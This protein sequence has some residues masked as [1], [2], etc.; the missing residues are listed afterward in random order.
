MAIQ[1]KTDPESGKKYYNV[2]ISIRSKLVPT[3]RVQKRKTKIETLNKARI[4]EKELYDKCY[5]ELYEKENRGCT[6]GAVVE[7]WNNY[8]KTD[9]FD[10]IAPHTLHDYTQSMRKWTQSIWDKPAKEVSRSD[11]KKV[12]SYMDEDG[13]SKNFQSKTKGV[14]NRIFTWG[15]EEE[16]ITGVLQSP[17]IGLKVSRRKERV[18]TILNKNEISILLKSAKEE[19]SPW[20]PIWFTAIHTGC[21][22]GELFALSWEDVDLSNNSIRVSKSFERRSSKIKSTKAGYW[23]NIPI[24][25]ALKQLLIELKSSS[26]S[27]FV[28]PRIREWRQGSQ[29]TELKKFCI[30][31][32]I[33]PIR[34]HDLRACFATQLLQNNISPATV[35]KICGWRDLDTMG[36]YIRLA[37]IDENGATNCL[38][39]K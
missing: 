35:M 3:L 1:V 18:P 20:Y 9:K 11:I 36:R 34:F 14:I 5:S 4:A 12:I 32:G 8:K 24:N 13:R 2:S 22:N 33:T 21:R 26:S 27:Q 16:I 29:A 23:R 31:I 37:G 6:W 38:T 7:K 15:I 25:S 30:G 10:P 28:L 19:N 17:T 39:F